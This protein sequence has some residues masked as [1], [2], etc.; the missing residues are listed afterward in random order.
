[1]TSERIPAPGDWAETELV[2]DDAR[3]EQGQRPAIFEHARG[4]VAVHVRPDG[5]QT[6]ESRGWS[7]GLVFGDGEDV[8]DRDPVREE[9]EDR[10]TAIQ[11]AKELM[12][13]LSREGLPQSP[14]EVDADSL[15][16]EE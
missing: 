7:V 15:L 11:Q 1:M 14:S 9:L 2:R 3:P 8:R 4:D 16:A 12:E 6:G 13:A 5:P 10:A